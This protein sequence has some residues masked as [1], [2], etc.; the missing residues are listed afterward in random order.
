MVVGDGVFGH[1][2]VLGFGRLL[3]KGKATGVGDLQE[4][5]HT[6]VATACEDDAD[7]AGDMVGLAG[8]RAPCTLAA[9]PGSAVS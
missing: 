1:G 3:D 8:A 2:G 5:L 9:C 6:V 4:T 7:D